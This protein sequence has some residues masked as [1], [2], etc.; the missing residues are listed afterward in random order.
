MDYYN[1][2]GGEAEMC[3]NGIRCLVLHEQ[4]AGRLG[5]GRA[6]RADARPDR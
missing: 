2:D 1:A 4:N 6:H 5:D 3:G